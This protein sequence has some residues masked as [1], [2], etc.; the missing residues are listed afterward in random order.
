[1]PLTTRTNTILL[2][3]TLIFLV[4]CSSIPTENST[5]KQATEEV[6]QK[7]QS[8]FD[9]LAA[10]IP[11]KKSSSISTKNKQKSTQQR[12]TWEAIKTEF[13][14]PDLNHDSIDRE[15]SILLSHPSILRRNLRTALPLVEFVLSE[16][17]KRNLPSEL[18]L[19]PFV[20]S[21]Y[22]LDARS[23]RKAKG[24]WQFVPNT[25]NSLGLQQSWWHDDTYNAVFSTEAALTY[26]ESLNNRFE[27]W[28]YA[29]A[30]Y[31][32]GPARLAKSISKL[33]NSKQ[34]HPF[35]SLQLPTETQRYIPKLFAYK[36]LI[37][38]Y[39]QYAH[40][41]DNNEANIKLAKLYIEKQTSLA[42]IAD[43]AS[44]DMAQLHDYNPGYKRWATP[45]T[46][47]AAL[48]LPRATVDEVHEKL[49]SLSHQQRMPW[50]LYR[51][52]PGDTLSEIAQKHQTSA[53][54]LK[55]LNA[56]NSDKIVAGRM[57]K[58]PTSADP[59]TSTKIL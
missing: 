29:I 22:T 36:K 46:G 57:L 59:V 8:A 9:H 58:I 47:R 38:N 51:I 17:N 25:A 2:A 52:R 53:I 45:P 21:G 7:E 37:A 49:L 40:L 26:L 1:M 30:A 11:A 23:P 4:S 35:F 14:L 54:E 13:S 15:L 20:E 18:A 16:V 39:E 33:K 31:N 24:L 28:V 5:P 41:F 32:S 19:I 10:V 43:I 34:P 48:L 27:D 55:K 44:F 12:S 6:N 42:I 50:S 56:L 3:L